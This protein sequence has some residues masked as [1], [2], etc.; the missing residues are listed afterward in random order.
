M[1]QT[2]PLKFAKEEAVKQA[3]DPLAVFDDIVG[4]YAREGFAAIDKDDA[5]RLK[6]FGVY[7]QRPKSEGRFM[8]RIKIPAGRLTVEQARHI[9]RLAKSH[10]KNLADI[11][12]RQTIQL[13]WL[14]AESMPDV[15]DTIYRKAGLFQ[16]FSCGDAPRNVTS[17]PLAG[18]AH[19]E[20]VDTSG[21]ARAV[22][23]LYYREKHEF[24]NLPRKW[25]TALGGCRLHCHVPQI[26][27]IAFFG[28][29]RERGGRT[30]R[31]LGL[32]VGGGLSSDPHFA[33]S[34]RVFLPPEEDLIV[35]VARHVT[36]CY[37]GMDHLRTNRRRARIKFHVADVG[38]KAFR[39][40]L[41]A[42]LGYRLEHDESIVDPVGAVTHDHMGVGEQKDGNRYIGLPVARGRIS[43][44]LLAAFADLVEAHAAPGKGRIQFT[45]KQN[46]VLLDID[47][48]RVDDAVRAAEELGFTTK[49]HPLVATF[50]TCTGSEFCNL[51]ISETKGVTRH[52]LDELTRRIDLDEPF[53]VAMTGCPNSCAHYWIGDVGLTG[54]KVRYRGE[55]CDAFLVL[56]GAKLGEQPRFGRE[57]VRGEGPRGKI[58]IP[59]PLIHETIARLVEAY[60][61]ERR[62]DDRFADWAGRQDMERLA[63][64]VTPAEL[65][66]DG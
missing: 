49:P 9:A 62:P 17:C 54:T 64:L 8:L 35:D 33:Q 44:D 21:L 42:S 34:L 6:W 26:N 50:L 7:I 52:A 41:E 13:H 20:I 47:P 19:D 3:R 32:A 27:D 53:F 22:S 36:R 5:M 2:K 25:K 46:L 38:W 12:T 31:G 24:S 23:D 65:A 39:D 15:M 56:V 14:T 10:G 51:A 18:I 66:A 28:V 43:G 48:A 29:E 30:E 16:E 59:A 60:Q 40:E 45:P 55:M 61:A 37:R 1:A 58:K 4:R 11:T 57:V 63:E